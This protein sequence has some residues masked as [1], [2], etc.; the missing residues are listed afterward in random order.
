MMLGISGGQRYPRLARQSQPIKELNAI[1]NIASSLSLNRVQNRSN[2][3]GAERVEAG[4]STV[5]LEST[6][7]GTSGGAADSLGESS[8]VFSIRTR[9]VSQ[10]KKHSQSTL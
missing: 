10:P 6:A 1:S 9:S 4:A 5:V 2:E 8:S 7:M 3:P